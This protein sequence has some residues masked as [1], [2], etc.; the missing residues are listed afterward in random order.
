MSYNPSTRRRVVIPSL[1]SRHAV[2]A[3]AAALLTVLIGSSAASA[4]AG[5]TGFGFNAPTISGA[6][7]AVFLSGGGAFDLTSELFF[8]NDPSEARPPPGCRP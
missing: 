2:T 1:K 6:S 8:A 7:G 5:N 3:V 4:S